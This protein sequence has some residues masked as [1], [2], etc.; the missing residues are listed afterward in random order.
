MGNRCAPECA[1][2]DACPLCKQDKEDS[3]SVLHTHDKA[4]VV[5]LELKRSPLVQQMTGIWYDKQTGQHMG[6]IFDDHLYWN[7]SFGLPPALIETQLVNTVQLDVQ[8]KT[9]HAQVSLEAQ[10]T[11]TW[12]DGSVWLRK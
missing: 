11:M 12:R 3:I 7:F 5:R 10:A 8:G 6:E 1:E 9:L 4:D 2:T